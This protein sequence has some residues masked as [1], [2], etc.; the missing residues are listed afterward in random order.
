MSASIRH[1]V[2][3]GLCAV[4]ALA[5]DPVESAEPFDETT[6][7]ETFR[8]EAAPPIWD[9]AR[10]V[11]ARDG[12]VRL[13][14]SVDDAGLPKLQRMGRS[15]RAA[16]MAERSARIRSA[17][18]RLAAQ[19]PSG[20][21][22]SRSFSQVPLAVVDVSDLASLNQLA[23]GSIAPAWFLDEPHERFLSDSLDLIEQPAA[24]AAGFTGAGTAV[25]VLDTGLDYTHSDF[26]SCT[27]PGVPA[28]C[29][30]VAT[31]EVAA[32][33]GS[34]DDNGHG[35]NVAAIVG[36]V[37]PG[38]ALIGMDVFRTDGYA[39]TSDI[40]SAIDWV[41]DH[42]ETYN[43][44]ALN[45]SLGGGQYTEECMWSAYEVA[46]AVAESAGVASAVATGNNGW[47]DSIS[48]PACAPTA[49]K[50]GAVYS[51]SYGRVGWSTCTDTSTAADQVTCFSNSASFIDL[52]APGAIITAGGY[53]MGGTSQA[54][55]HVA[56]ALAVVAEAYPTETPSQ[57]TDRLIDTGVD[58][59]DS[60]NSVT[61]PRIDVEAA[62]LDAVEGDPPT[63]SLSLDGGA[64]YTNYRGVD[65]DLVVQDGTEPATEMCLANADNGV[66]TECTDWEALDLEGRWWLSSGQ[67][68]KTVSVWVRDDAG[69]TSS[70]ATA[71]ITLDTIAPEDG[72]AMVERSGATV[73]LTWDAAADGSSGVVSYQV[74]YLEGD[75]APVDCASG[76]LVYEGGATGTEVD[77]LDPTASHA[78]RICAVDL[79][80]NVSAGVSATLAASDELLGSVSIDGG[81]AFTAQR[82]VSLALDAPGADEMCL[83]NTPRCADTAW[84]AYEPNLTWYLPNAEGVQ[85][86][87]VWFR[88]SDGT[89]SEVAEAEIEVD[90]T[91]PE[92]A[93][94]E[95]VADRSSRTVAVSWADFADEGSGVVA[96]RIGWSGLVQVSQ[97]QGTSLRGTDADTL[98]TTLALPRG[99][100]GGR[101]A[102]WAVDA[103]G[104]VSVAGTA[105]VQ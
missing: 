56:G 41:V 32:D 60:R 5:C 30:V 51:K 38:T 27:A 54:T 36:G 65:A 100:V 53:R 47:T 43:I 84:R 40:V 16:A 18:D 8:A 70:P 95:A 17:T 22:L 77:D 66:P 87:S 90:W 97:Q 20:A 14:A 42:Q 94:V 89:V 76:S 39:Y 67:G 12:S 85:T 98:F 74:A 88:T 4:G 82:E 2:V 24:E 48:S 31:E 23:A 62:I 7:S 96:Y 69:R 25:A 64:P 99:A 104:N 80:G 37:A 73:E 44:V 93:A 29:R 78:F 21:Q 72:E 9:A 105:V 45:M 61:V 10:A 59:T 6:V 34:L 46:M 101:V 68:D 83:S 91:A 3:W 1:R 26:G 55:P 15:G 81:A 49:I 103:A 33:D 71:E 28:A 86:V 79:A 58:V 102:V 13:L 35:T 50:V 11:L 75:S 52:L 63:V 92:V 57:W 19:L